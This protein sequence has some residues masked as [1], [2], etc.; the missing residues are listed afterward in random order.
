MISYKKL[1]AWTFSMEVAKQIYTLTKTYPSDERYGLISQTRRAAVSIPCNI[2]EGLG[3]NQKKTPY[4][5]FILPEVLLMNWKHY[6]VWP[7]KLK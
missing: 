6:Y 2:A 5:S 1:E 4:N 3:R 7:S